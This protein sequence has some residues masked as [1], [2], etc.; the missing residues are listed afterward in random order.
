MADLP[1]LAVTGSS[2]VLGGMA[3]RG[4][5]EA[6]FSQRLLVRPVNLPGQQQ[7]CAG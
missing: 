3:A 2:G 5:A 6:G 1:D 7:T 4:L